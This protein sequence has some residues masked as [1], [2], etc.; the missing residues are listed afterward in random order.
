MS[1][2]RAAVP[3]LT[4]IAL[5]SWLAG[6]SSG[7]EES[8]AIVGDSITAFDQTALNEQLGGDFELVITGNYG[9]TVDQVMPEAEV[10]AQRDY[11]QV[12][13]N[14]GTNDVLQDLPVDQSMAAL[15]QMIELFGDARCIHLVNINEH[16]LEPLSK[17]STTAAA[18]RFNA[19][20]QQ[21]VDADDQLSVLDWNAV[22]AGSLN[23]EDPPWS[24]LTEDSVHPTPEGNTRLN[25]LYRDALDRCE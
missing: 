9:K 16:M 24:T 15:R 4:T 20:Q 21:V 2:R 8:V 5:T 11:D 7:P 19:A 10:V 13:I 6:C 1:L 17:E 14:L 3:V 25:D 18:Q 23:D 22:A 12:I